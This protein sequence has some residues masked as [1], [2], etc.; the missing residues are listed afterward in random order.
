MGWDLVLWTHFPPVYF[1]WKDS[2]VGER[3]ETVHWLHAR[4]KK[5]SHSYTV[6][7][8]HQISIEMEIYLEDKTLTIA[9]VTTRYIKITTTMKC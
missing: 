6:K 2:L 8:L 5:A 3:G 9:P 7:I 4:L 1:A